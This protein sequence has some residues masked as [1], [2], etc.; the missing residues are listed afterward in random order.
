MFIF[1]R[2]QNLSLRH[3]GI[4]DK[5]AIM[6]GRCLGST[7]RSNVKLISLNLANNKIT[8]AGLEEIAQVKNQNFSLPSE[9]QIRSTEDHSKIIFL[10]SQGKCIL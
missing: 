7:K 2:V 4:T 5:G 10:I 6:I 9:L 1:F 3:C 8:D